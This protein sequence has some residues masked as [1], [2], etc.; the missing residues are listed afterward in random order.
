MGVAAAVIIRLVVYSKQKNAKKYRKGMEYGTARWGTQQDI[1]PYVDPAFANNV[2]LTQTERLTMSSRPKD[3]KNRAE[4]E[5]TG[6]GR[7]RQRQDA[8]FH[9]AQ[10]H[11]A[12]TAHTL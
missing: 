5:R 2:M 8:V 12:Y 3:P 9:Q 10:P 4:Q 7:L 11:A 1:K 6:G